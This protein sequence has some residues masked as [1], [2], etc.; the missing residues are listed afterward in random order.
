MNRIFGA[1]L[2]ATSVIGSIA[3]AQNLARMNSSW[4]RLA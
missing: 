1:V 2:V 4:S 3:H